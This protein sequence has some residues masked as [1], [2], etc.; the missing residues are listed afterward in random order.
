MTLLEN[1]LLIDD[2]KGGTIHDY[3]DNYGNEKS[4]QFTGALE[5]DYLKH[6]GKVSYSTL[7]HY[8]GT[9]GVHIKWSPETIRFYEP[10]I[11]EIHGGI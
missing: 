7:N 1:L 3:I 9:Y 8:A 5:H 4:M 10:N 6:G 11:R 2:K